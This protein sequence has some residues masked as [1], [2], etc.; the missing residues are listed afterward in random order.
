MAAPS[1]QARLTLQDA[2]ERFASTVTPDD[3]RLFHNT[4]LKDVRDEA[5][6]I[7]RQLRARRMQRNMARLDPFLRGMEHYSK[8]VEVLCN[9]TPY[10][11]WIWAPV[12]LMLMI[13]VDSI[14]AFEKLID[15]YGK[16]ADVLPRLDRLSNALV[17]DQNF[18]NVLA[19][20][21]SDIVEF[22]RRAYK[23]VKR[24]SWAIYFG[25]M[26]AGFESR[27]D[28]ILKNLAYHTDL[29]DKEAAAADIS[30]AV[31]RSKSNEEKWEQ[32]EREWNAIKVREVLA[33][34]ETEATPPART[35]E[36]HLKGCLPDS[37]DW[38]VK[39]KTTQLWLGTSAKNPLVW[40]YG[41]PGAG[42]SVLCSTLV[43]HAEAS[44]LD[45]FYYFCSF[46]GSHS[47]G[48]NRLLRSIITQVIQK[49]QVLATYVHD[50]YFKS[51]PIHT[52]K[53]LLG[54][55]TELL[56]GLGPVRL[57][58][59][60]IDE[61]ESRDQKE[62]FKDLEQL[63]TPNQPSHIC[64][65]LIASRET[66]HISRL[67][68]K[69]DKSAMTICLSN[70]EEGLAVT[71]SIAKFVDSKLSDLP[72]HFDDFDHDTSILVHV[73]QTLLKKSHGM[74]LW[75]TLVLEELDTIYTPEDLRAVV[76]DLPSDIETL[77]K[78]IMVR[79][80]SAPGAQSHGGV[81]RILSWICFARRPLHKSELLQALSILPQE[82]ASHGR[83]IPVA[84]ILDHC[85]PLIE[86]LPDSTIVPVHFSVKEFL[87]KSH[88]SQS[89][90]ANDAALDILCVCTVVI[91]RSLDLLRLECNPNDHLTRIASGHYR[92]LPYAME[93]WVEHC[94]QYAS[95]GG[96]LGHDQ[97][98][99]QHLAKLHEK[100]S[101]LHDLRQTTVQVETLDRDNTSYADESLHLF[102]N[103]P[104]CSIMAD[105]LSLRRLTSQ[106]DGENSSNIEKYAMDN[107]HTLFSRLAH[108]YESAVTYLLAQN[109]V[110]GIPL[111]TLRAFQQSYSSTAFR[112][113]FPH[114]DRLSLGFATT[115]LRLKHEA[116][117]I[118]RV[119]CR[120]LSC[121]Y[122]RIGFAKKKALDAHTRKHHG[123][124]HVLLIPAK[125]RRAT[126]DEVETGPTST[127]RQ[128]SVSSPI[129]APLSQG[130]INVQAREHERLQQQAQ[131]QPNVQASQSRQEDMINQ[132]AKRL[133]DTCKDDVRRIFQ[134]D[135]QSWPEDKKQQL[136]AQGINPLFFRFRQHA[137][138]LYKKGALG[139]MRSYTGAQNSTSS[140]SSATEVHPYPSPEMNGFPDQNGSGR[141][142]PGAAST[143]Q[144][145][146]N[147][148]YLTPQ[149]Q[150]P[151]SSNLYNVM[152]DPT[153]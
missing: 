94:S 109:E 128:M 13:T 74:F 53:A 151:P 70:V 113:R 77:Y 83:S 130:T 21:Y 122:S 69:K 12:K 57:V 68:R 54:L 30:E 16:I 150:A 136:V 149:R 75:V 22:H 35:L 49:H 64:K 139:N 142:A 99:Q 112:C 145:Q 29:A 129:H 108:K 96:S 7:E 147:S 134:E 8:V 3:R 144:K 84:S 138:L 86:E 47:D 26:W 103:L 88:I 95:G 153:Q 23:L 19:L 24:K 42:K 5:M 141:A 46:L 59:D 11:S 27:F 33:W 100:H 31:R 48:P 72:E 115:E 80:C 66:I 106:F 119:Y 93:F 127:V 120:T 104:I 98:L 18:Q 82:F 148:G 114:C 135:V 78:H 41:K 92:L 87:L 58:V 79:L 61:W 38:F 101:T 63:I 56:R 50:V 17:D 28:T 9:G 14:S 20:V 15:A 126:D 6:R 124:S 117:H 137:E 133:M 89:I 132:F 152:S 143:V 1:A 25:S 51:H 44:N 97:P 90:P 116:S 73:K 76:D 60:G 91:M 43:Q 34:L 110:E 45:V 118:Q 81:A 37:C 39:H 52:K 32:Q 111:A 10:L 107:D 40:L 146:W 62:L 65:I 71:G 55:L 85:K 102:S 67:L 2:F 123:K 125:V 121:Q 140:Q 36:R 131:Q 105:V 4:E